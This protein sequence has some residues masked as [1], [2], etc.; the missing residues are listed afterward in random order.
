[1]KKEIIGFWKPL[2]EAYAFIWFALNVSYVAGNAYSSANIVFGAN[3]IQPGNPLSTPVVFNQ[4]FL[5]LN[6]IVLTCQPAIGYTNANI[7]YF[8][9]PMNGLIRSCWTS[10]PKAYVQD[11]YAN[12][13]T[14]SANTILARG[15]NTLSMP[16]NLKVTYSQFSP[17]YSF[18]L[19]SA[20][21]LASNSFSLQAFCFEASNVV[22]AIPCTR[23]VINFT[24]FNEQTNAALS[25]T[26]SYATTL[27]FN[28]YSIVANATFTANQINAY[29]SNSGFQNPIISFFNQTAISSAS[30][31]QPVENDYFNTN[32]NNTSWQNLHIYLPSSLNLNSSFYAFQVSQCNSYAINDYLVSTLG[33]SPGTQVQIYKIKNGHFQLPLLNGYSYSFTLYDI[34]KNILNQSGSSIWTSPVTLSASCSNNVPVLI[35]PN[36]SASCTWNVLSPSNELSASCTGTDKSNKVSSW[37]INWTFQTSLLS[38]HVVN[39]V[40]IN[41]SSFTANYIFQNNSRSNIANIYA[42]IGSLYDPTELFSILLGTAVSQVLPFSS[43]FIGIIFLLIPIVAAYFDRELLL[44]IF[45]I[46]VVIIQAL[47]LLNFGVYDVTGLLLL[48]GVVLFLDFFLYRKQR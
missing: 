34:N 42:H 5:P 14:P 40:N 32:L 19:T 24:S 17:S 12:S 39:S 18:N 15:S 9:I 13:T 46:V 37:T 27:L 44:I 4:T 29:A 20:S 47:G 41:G 33:A 10:P 45:D 23:R 21:G 22:P 8:P 2:L 48:S 26:T 11:G 35:G 30:N 36:I 28:N 3:E 43:Y 6:S 25:A 38:S 16:D 31:F 7:Q 1:M